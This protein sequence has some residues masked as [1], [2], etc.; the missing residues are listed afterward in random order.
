MVLE[1]CMFVGDSSSDK[2]NRTLGP[3]QLG[4]VVVMGWNMVVTVLEAVAVKQM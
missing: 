4:T 3:N 1:F 2:P